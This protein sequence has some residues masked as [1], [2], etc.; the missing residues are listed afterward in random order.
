MWVVP[1]Y[2][3]TFYDLQDC[4]LDLVLKQKWRGFEGDVAVHLHITRA[5]QVWTLLKTTTNS[6]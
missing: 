4:L 3:L 6:I 2:D 5:C 1:N